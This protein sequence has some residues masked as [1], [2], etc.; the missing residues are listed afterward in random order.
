M[1]YKWIGSILIITGCGGYGFLLSASD[2]RE[3][4]GLRELI[5]IL[6]YISCELQF[7]LTPLPEIC[8]KAGSQVKGNIGML[9]QSLADIMDSME[10]ADVSDCM[11]KALAACPEIPVSCKT[12]LT[13]LGDTLGCFGLPGQLSELG[14][15]RASC[16]SVLAELE[17]GKTQRIRSYQTLGLCTGAALAILLV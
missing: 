1:A 15:V 13:L 4:S 2:R 9:F 10:Q 3:M 8:R 5:R 11:N 6:E 14:S 17:K 7:H 12:H 16:V